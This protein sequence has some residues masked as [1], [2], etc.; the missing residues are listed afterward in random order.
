M[1]EIKVDA[2]VFI[3]LQSLASPFVDT[4][5][6]VLRRI[7]GIDSREADIDPPLVDDEHNAA[8]PT[9][10]TDEHPPIPQR[11]YRPYI[12]SILREAGGSLSVNQVLKEVE[13]RMTSRFSDADYQPVSKDEVKWRNAARWERNDM[14]KDGLIKKNGRRGVWELTE[15][16]MSTE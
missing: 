15:G 13:C 8:G 7:L 11:E 9:E 16:G 6:D 2:E 12:L 14:V 1:H 10:T 4:P 3:R 5:N